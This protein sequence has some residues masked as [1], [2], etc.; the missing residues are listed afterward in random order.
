MSNERTPYLLE[1]AGLIEESTVIFRK[2]NQ[3]IPFPGVSVERVSL[4]ANCRVS[5]KLK[6]M[7]K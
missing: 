3:S 2:F 4:L 7:L 1:V 5:I 6:S